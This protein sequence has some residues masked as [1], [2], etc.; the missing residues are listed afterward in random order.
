MSQGISS[1][2]TTV[3]Y[4]VPSHHKYPKPSTPPNMADAAVH[5]ANLAAFNFEPY[6]TGESKVFLTKAAQRT[7]YALPPERADLK[8]PMEMT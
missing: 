6:R 4:S 3:V 5:H 2:C 1:V 7:K 8:T